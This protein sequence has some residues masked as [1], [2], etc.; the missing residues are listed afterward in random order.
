MTR[1]FETDCKEF[2]KSYFDF[3]PQQFG[4]VLGGHA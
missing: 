3:S 1:E 2:S 4:T